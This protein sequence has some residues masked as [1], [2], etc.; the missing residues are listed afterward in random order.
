MGELTPWEIVL[1]VCGLL[2]GL[3][4]I[5]NTFGSAF[6]KVAKAKKALKA[7]NDEQDRRITANE[8]DIKD[9]KGLL[10]KDKKR[11]DTLEDGNRV[12]QRA[13]LALLGHGLDGNNQKQMADA[14]AELESHLI[15]R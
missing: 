15:N 7:P 2:L 3:A 4:T 11:L 10:G 1:L 9:I 6:E 14:K 8:N 5:I 13:L 12:T